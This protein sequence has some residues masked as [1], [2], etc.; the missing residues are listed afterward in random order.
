MAIWIGGN[1][2]GYGGRPD[3]NQRVYKLPDG[4]SWIDRASK[5][6]LVESPFQ[7][8]SK[9]VLFSQ[10]PIGNVQGTFGVGQLHGQSPQ[11]VYSLSPLFSDL[12]EF[13]EN[14]GGML[15][16]I[17]L[18]NVELDAELN[19]ELNADLNI[20]GPIEEEVLLLSTPADLERFTP[21]FTNNT[22]LANILQIPPFSISPNPY[23][24]CIT[25]LFFITESD[26][27]NVYTNYPYVLYL[28]QIYPEH[29]D[30]NAPVEMDGSIVGV[31]PGL[32]PNILVA[33]L[34]SLNYAFATL[35]LQL[36]QAEITTFRG[37]ALG[38]LLS[39]I[40]VSIMDPLYVPL[41]EHF[42]SNGFHQDM[43]EAELE[44]EVAR[45]ED[46]LRQSRNER[47][48]A[49][50]TQTRLNTIQRVIDILNSI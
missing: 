40:D 34:Y 12:S 18:N 39:N 20:E 4:I 38:V 35:L 25:Y 23:A 46:Y 21:I 45:V 5:T 27:N 41:I 17:E 29:L 37:E 36:P 24:L 14:G 42:I 1:T 7:Y 44:T 32:Y 9:T 49:T 13:K 43:S 28:S 16:D 3:L 11:T 22:P 48:R 33:S 19:A 10:I 15:S 47:R 6:L 50:P 30:I 31:Q 2:E 26:D 8:F